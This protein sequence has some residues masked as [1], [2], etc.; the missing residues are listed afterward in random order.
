M[1]REKTDV[2]VARFRADQVTFEFPH[3]KSRIGVAITGFD[4]YEITFVPPT[5]ECTVMNIINNKSNM[6]DSCI[7]VIPD[8]SH[9][10]FCVTHAFERNGRC[11]SK[12]FIKLE[13]CQLR[14][15]S[16]TAIWKPTLRLGP[17]WMTKHLDNYEY[18]VPATVVDGKVDVSLVLPG[19]PFPLKQNGGITGSKL[20]KLLKLFSNDNFGGWRGANMAFGRMYECIG[21]ACYLRHFPER[22]GKEVG[23]LSIGDTLDGNVPDL[24]VDGYIPLEIKCS[25]SNCNFEIYHI[26]Q[27]IWDCACGYPFTDLVKYCE[28]AEKQPG[29]NVWQQVRE[30]KVT[31]V[32]RN[33][34]LEERIIAYVK[35]EEGDLKRIIDQLTEIAKTCNENST[36]IPVDDALVADLIQ[37]R[38][39]VTNCVEDS[40]S[41]RIEKRHKLIINGAKELILDQI[42]DYLNL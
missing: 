12:I 25:R 21:I 27:C 18:I 13:N 15:D 36:Q 35:Y 24:L 33:K 5:S 39:N 28:R 22:R 14:G 2:V 6:I 10:T 3:V 23:F 30:C 19:A 29:T 32:E 4:A 11:V 9:D 26:V 1:K 41:E 38:Q 37:F 31:R 8:D 20:G 16:E 17:F 42:R 7:A 40:I 34:E